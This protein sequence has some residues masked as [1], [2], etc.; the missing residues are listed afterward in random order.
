MPI[1]GCFLYEL[2][3]E[4]VASLIDARVDKIHQPLKDEL[5]ILFRAYK[6][7]YKLFI[8]VNP[9]VSR[10]YITDK[11]PENPMK[12]PML[13]MLLRKHLG[14]AKLLDIQQTGFERVLTFLFETT[15]EMGDIVHPKLIVELIGKQTNAILVGDDGRIIDC[16][17]RS[18]IETSSRILQ[19]G[20]KYVYPESQEKFNILESDID[21]VLE[22]IKQQSGSLDKALLSILDGVSPLVCRELVFKAF[23]KIDI[24]VSDVDFESFKNVILEF[25]CILSSGGTPI[26]IKKDNNEIDFSFMPIKQYGES[27]KNN[28]KENYSKLLFDYYNERGNK[29]RMNTLKSDLS[30]TLNNLKNRTERKI[31]ARKSDYKKCEKRETLRIYGELIKANLYR[32]EKGSLFAEVENYYDEKNSLVKIPLNSAVS[33]AENAQRYFKEYKKLCIA[34][35]TLIDL[36]SESEQELFYI[37]SII[38]ALSR[39]ETSD[40]LEGIREE[41]NAS[42]YIKQKNQKD[43]RN[44]RCVSFKEYISPDGFRILV[45]KNNKQNDELTFKVAQKQDLWLHSKNIAGSH[46]IIV[47]DGKQAPESTIIFAA[48]LAA[49]NSKGCNSSN[50]PVDCVPVKFVKKPN[51]A[52]PGMVIFTNNKTYFVTPDI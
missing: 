43:K 44:L 34:S 30:K 11:V 46:V 47:T 45:G 5:V 7:T 24:A 6:H 19:S 41:V 32:I 13:C 38:D 40:E 4:L 50:V 15:N 9:S 48:K 52:K 14:G 51:G 26:I 18:D 17:K 36:I 2:K 33:P 8:D 31:E 1:D 27:Y 12:P 16:I 29:S 10:L 35:N 3:T 25:R 28:I 49:K 21:I 37:E 20:A 42:G 22:K 39:V 23:G